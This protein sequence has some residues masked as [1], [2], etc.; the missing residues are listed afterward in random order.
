MT[1][2][3]KHS[4]DRNFLAG[5]LW[6]MI[7][8]FVVMFSTSLLRDLSNFIF[9]FGLALIVAWIFAWFGSD[10][11]IKLSYQ[12]VDALRKRTEANP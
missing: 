11:T 1:T 9:L 12:L 6:T 10:K 5:V 7:G 4:M 3:D 2:T 8:T